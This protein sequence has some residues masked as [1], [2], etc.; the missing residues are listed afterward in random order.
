MQVI[1]YLLATGGSSAGD[2]HLNPTTASAWLA[3]SVVK[4]R[5]IDEENWLE[6]A[7]K[8]GSE[9]V[10]LIKICSLNMSPGTRSG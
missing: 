9:N 5:S 8:S 7:F 4:K 2:G 1:S 6:T 3:H 10:R